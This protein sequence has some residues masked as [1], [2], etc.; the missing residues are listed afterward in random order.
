MTTP[1]TTYATTENPAGK[2]RQGTR[3]RIEGLPVKAGNGLFELESPFLPQPHRAGDAY[4]QF[5]RV[6]RDGKVIDSVA[7]RNLR[8]CWASALD[9]HAVIVS[10]PAVAS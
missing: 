6:G 5:R 9:R 7:T 10:E 1:T 8:G 3:I 2:Y 4:V